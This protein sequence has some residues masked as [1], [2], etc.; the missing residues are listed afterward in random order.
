MGEAKIVHIDGWK[1]ATMG[2]GVTRIRDLDLAQ[3]LGYKR[4]HDIRELIGR[5]LKDG[6]L[7]DSEV[8]RT[9][10]KTQGGGRPGQEFWL[11]RP[12]ALKV[13]AKSETE[14]ADALLDEMI[15]VFELVI[16]GGLVARVPIPYLLEQVLLLKPAEHE[17][18]WPPEFVRAICTLYRK[19]WDGGVQP[20]WMSGVYSRLYGILITKT[21]LA[22]LK[23]RNPDPRFRSNHHQYLQPDVRERLLREI[24][25][26][27]ALAEQSLD[28]RDFW[29]RV[30]FKYL[31]KPMTQ[32]LFRVGS[33]IGA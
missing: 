26:L 30:E 2:D 22:E 33:G 15:R 24:P 27:I 3:R 16:D 9:V 32:W 10:R 29:E 19:R 25:V 7:N 18:T 13:A 20:Q 23:R 11:T 28:H 6:K 1:L 4:P 17:N 8:L 12:Q 5:L 21:A 14:P 31:K